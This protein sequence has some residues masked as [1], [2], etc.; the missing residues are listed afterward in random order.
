MDY[1]KDL[2]S[3][4]FLS[5][6]TLP[7]TFLS[8]L[9][10]LQKIKEGDINPVR[11]NRCKKDAQ[12][13]LSSWIDMAGGLMF[14]RY[15][16]EFQQEFDCFSE[17]LH[18]DILSLQKKFNQKKQKKIKIAAKQFLNKIKEIPELSEVFVICLIHE[19]DVVKKF[20]PSKPDSKVG[21]NTTKNILGITPEFEQTVALNDFL[22]EERIKNEKILQ[23]LYIQTPYGPV[24]KSLLK[25]QTI[26][27]E[28]HS[29]NRSK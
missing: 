25:S 20:I 9:K 24:S 1:R 6:D 21:W 27:I 16:F 11:F 29:R 28:D 8:Y 13:L 12:K 7:K 5:M 4:T 18:R 22:E 14:E 10:E 15:L 19:E 2:V 23:E 3:L 17:N 26:K